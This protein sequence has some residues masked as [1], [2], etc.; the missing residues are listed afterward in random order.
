[1][2][3]P[4]AASS[5]HE[6]KAEDATDWNQTWSCRYTAGGAR[7]RWGGGAGQWQE[8]EPDL[9]PQAAVGCGSRGRGVKRLS[10]LYLWGE[11]QLHLKMGHSSS[12]G[13]WFLQ[14]QKLMDFSAGPKAL[15]SLLLNG[16]YLYP[17]IF[18]RISSSLSTS[19]LLFSVVWPKWDV[20][21][22]PE[23]LEKLV[24]SFTL[25]FSV[26]ETF[27]WLEV[28]LL[29]M[30]SASLRLGWCSQNNTVL[31]FLFVQLFSLLLLL[32]FH[33]VAELVASWALPE[34]FCLWIAI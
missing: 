6:C 16:C 15:W 31:P 10:G 22:V 21:V 3:I 29:E 23:K 24:S 12:A 32:L 5:C 7:F 1:M 14:W 18:I 20:N 17:L 19:T 33:C 34:L 9:G 27:S 11:S 8:T 4:G 26:R 13:H 28:F 30:S 2:C 25:P